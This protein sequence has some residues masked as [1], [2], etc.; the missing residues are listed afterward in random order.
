MQHYTTNQNYE[1]GQSHSPSP[2]L[3]HDVDPFK[4]P[5]A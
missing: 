3:E 5:D 1:Q 2:P 4:S